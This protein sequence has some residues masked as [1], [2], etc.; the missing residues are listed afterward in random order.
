VGVIGAGAWGTTL[1]VLAV[2][3]G[4][5]SVLH[6]RDP[7]LAAEIDVSR[8]NDRAQPGLILPVQVQVS[9]DLADVCTGVDV[10]VVAVPSQAMRETAKAIAPYAGDAVVVSA[11]KGLERGSFKR[12]TEVLRDELPAAA[13]S[14][15]CTLSGP[16]LAGEI[17]AGKPAV[18]VVA[19]SSAAAAE[20]VRDLLMSPR[21][22]CYT[23]E[24]VVGVEMGGALKNIVAI[25]AGM[26]DGMEAGDNAKAAFLTRGIAEIA[27]LGM[28]VGAQPLT[29]AGLAGLGDLVAT[30]ASP[31][32]RNHRVGRE[33][34]KG[35]ALPEVL[36]E[37][38]H[39]AEGVTSTEVAFAL[40]NKLGVLLPIIEQMH[41]VLFEGKSPL[42]AV[43]QLMGREPKHELA[44]LRDGS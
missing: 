23:N 40:G 9:S 15:V 37:L 2:R 31:L 34:A 21:F 1:A 29:F 22:R 28:A 17:A 7:I 13:A 32:S 30:C 43:D 42:E 6:V 27:R 12:M 20:R 4:S 39:V 5:G 24:D 38:G 18:T 35:R 11:A 3:A 26:A 19:G 10:I 33:L 36:N 16:N 44:G 41:A 25:G 8:R 14:R